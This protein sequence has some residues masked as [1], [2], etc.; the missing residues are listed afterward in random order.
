[1]DLGQV[2]IVVSENGITATLINYRGESTA[3]LRM[4]NLN[5][6]SSGTIVDCV[7][8]QKLI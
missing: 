4:V 6:T 3:Y 1:M 7:V 8:G 5:Q 2:D